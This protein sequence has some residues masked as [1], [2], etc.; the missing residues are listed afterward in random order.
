MNSYYRTLRDPK[1]NHSDESKMELFSELE[2]QYND[3]AGLLGT[4]TQKNTQFDILKL[5]H[6]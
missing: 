2:Q 6:M 5:Y 3:I 1:K 4:F